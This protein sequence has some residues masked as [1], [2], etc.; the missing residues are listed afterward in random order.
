MPCTLA[1]KSTRSRASSRRHAQLCIPSWMDGTHALCGRDAVG[2]SW[3]WLPISRATT[4]AKSTGRRRSHRF[5]GHQ[6]HKGRSEPAGHVNRYDTG[7]EMGTL[8]PSGETKEGSPSPHARRSPGWHWRAETR[9][10]SS[11]AM[12]SACASCP[13]DRDAHAETIMRRIEEDITLSSPVFRTCHLG[14]R[15]CGRDPAPRTIVASRT[16]PSRS[17]RASPMTS[18]SPCLCAAG[19]VV[20]VRTSTRPP[21]GR[22]TNVVDVTEGT[23]SSSSCATCSWPGG[24]NLVAMRRQAVAQMLVFNRG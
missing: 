19:V 24:A 21:S 23:S 9:S 5:A 15:R 22:G 3:I 16:P 13:P 20:S 17:R 10:A 11:P 8:A 12:P 2:S 4:C 1:A 14:A 6:R 7:R 18:S